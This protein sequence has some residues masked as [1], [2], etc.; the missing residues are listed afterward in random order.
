MTQRTDP[1]FANSAESAFFAAVLA[2]GGPARTVDLAERLG[3]R[4]IQGNRRGSESAR[5]VARTL[6]RR[7]LSR[8]WQDAAGHWHVAPLDR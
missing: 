3:W 2:E 8:A 6:H 5:I 4:K 1:T 7:G